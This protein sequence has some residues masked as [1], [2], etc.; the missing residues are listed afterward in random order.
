MDVGL[1]QEVL[2]WF[3]SPVQQALGSV[4]SEAFKGVLVLCAVNRCHKL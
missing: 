4:G 1:V 2:Q 3:S